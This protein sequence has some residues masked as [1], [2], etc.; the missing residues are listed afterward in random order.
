MYIIFFVY[1]R[2][3]IYMTLCMNISLG[4]VDGTSVGQ[5]AIISRMNATLFEEMVKI[6]RS[7]RTLK[8]G[9]AGVSMYI[10]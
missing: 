3:Y 1:I 6:V 5:V 10:L 9:F 7:R 4:S 8:L 2:T